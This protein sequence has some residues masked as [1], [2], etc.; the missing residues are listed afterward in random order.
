MVF[1]CLSRLFDSMFTNP[2]DGHF[3]FWVSG[4]DAT[5]RGYDDSNSEVLVG[6]ENALNDSLIG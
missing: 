2:M 4:F 5:V 1:E 3:Y 6:L